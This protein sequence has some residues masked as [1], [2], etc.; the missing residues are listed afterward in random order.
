[1]D[2]TEAGHLL[3][4]QMKTLK[5]LSYSE[6]CSWIKSGKSE[7]PLVKGQSGSEYCIELEVRWEDKPGGAIRV[8]GSIDDGG[9]ASIIPLSAD[10]IVYPNGQPDNQC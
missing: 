4:E 9:W 8:L 3:N 6:L 2:K 5:C 1:M 7:T 10:F